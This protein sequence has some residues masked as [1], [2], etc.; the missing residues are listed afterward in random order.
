MCA[1]DEYLP[2]N[3]NITPVRAVVNSV[4]AVAYGLHNLWKTTC[5][6]KRGMCDKFRKIKREILLNYIKN[7]SFPD[8]A[9]NSTVKFN[10][11]GEVDGNYTVVNFRREATKFKYVNVGTWGG[12]VD[13][14]GEI[15]GH[16]KIED[17]NVYFRGGAR[18]PPES[19]CSRPCR[20]N[21]IKKPQTLNS[22]CC[23]DCK[24]CG[25]NDIVINNTCVSCKRGHLAAYNRTICEKVPVVYPNWGERGGIA[26]TM[27]SS[28]GILGVDYTAAFLIKNRNHQVIKAAGR[29][30]SSILLIGI[31]LCYVTTVVYLTKPS[32]VVCGLRRCMGN[33]S[34]TVCY[35]PVLLKTNRIHRIFVGARRSTAPPLFVSPKWSILM[36][37][38]IISVQ[39]LLSTLWIL[40]DSPESTE[41]YPSKECI[42]LECHLNS[43]SI[44][45]SLLYNVFLMVLCTIY[46]FKTRNFPRNFNEAKYV[47]V[48][49]YVTCSISIIF[50]TS[51]L[52]ATDYFVK[53]YLLCGTLTTVG[54]ITLL[55]LF[56][57]KIWLVYY[58]SDIPALNQQPSIARSFVCNSLV[59]MRG[60]PMDVEVPN[61]RNNFS[62]RN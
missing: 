50:I 56:G 9:F 37:L 11:N 44:A 17:N 29:E 5:Q 15:K 10:K 8:S 54:T 42:H 47:G 7:V 26:L 38:C 14:N 30:L 46:A 12:T 57:P 20:M 53:M 21:Q 24:D 62:Q 49:M 60:Q 40:S 1:S 59:E 52:Y 61:E 31:S 19:L 3:L 34:L 18:S 32:K 4:Y 41:T 45:V 6:K 23:W 55:G 35:A 51:Y 58:C 36:S 25:E 39:I 13:E 33:L 48:T 22:N 2:R 27:L 43:Y 16:L 28:I